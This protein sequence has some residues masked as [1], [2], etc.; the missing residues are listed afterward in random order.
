MKTIN[1]PEYFNELSEGGKMRAIERRVAKAETT[2]AKVSVPHLLLTTALCVLAL[3]I[4][5]TMR[6][7][8]Q[9]MEPEVVTQYETIHDRE[10]WDITEDEQ[11]LVTRVVS[12]M[13]RGETPLTMEAVAQ[14][15]R[16]TC[17]TKNMTVAEAVEWGR[18]PVDQKVIGQPAK[19]AVARVVDGYNAVDSTILYAYN[20]AV[21]DGS[22]HETLDFVCQIGALR[23]FTE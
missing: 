12:A 9:P 7:E 2:N 5:M 14:C 22:W 21:Q 13:A 23:F 19:D 20:P 18:F 1:I 3:A 10:A 16:N 15:V 6:P 4:G 17:E 11:M 8:A